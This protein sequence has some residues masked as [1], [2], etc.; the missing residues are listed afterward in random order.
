MFLL[1]WYE[2][3]GFSKA[4]EGIEL[5]ES[6][7]GIRVKEYPEEGLY[8]YNYSQIE[9]PKMRP[10][11][12]ECR[13][14]ILNENL[15]IVCLPFSRF[16][17]I[18]EA[19]E[20]TSKFNI[21]NSIVYEKLDGSLC[22]VY[23]D[24]KT[25]QVA[26]RGTAFAESE[27]YTGEIFQKLILDA[28]ECETLQDFS[29][30]LDLSYIPHTWTLIFEY[31][32]PMNRVVT[33]YKEDCMYLL[34]VRDTVTTADLYFAEDVVADALIRNDLNVKLP[35]TFKFN[36]QE[37]MKEFVNSLDGLQEGVVALDERSGIRIKVKADQYVAI[38]R[39]R[40]D[41]I[42]TPKRI[43]NLIVTNETEEYLAYFPEERMRFE[44]YM[45][46]FAKLQYRIQE[47]WDMSKNIEDQKEFALFVKD[48]MFS[49]VLFQ[50]RQR[51][52]E[53]LHI[54]ATTQVNQKIKLFEK[55]FN[56]KD[57]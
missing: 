5:L 34:G 46:S 36:N 28:F 13:G 54:L 29:N 8:V 19:L 48:Y 3:K 16:F 47:I 55:W 38:H 39:L 43:M 51:E 45:E 23:H 11:V 33:P 35:K 32:S 57:L 17:N 7:F 56:Y 53:P 40:G 49:P 44:P 30:R 1:E 37:E 21:E 42:P 14:L 22:K 26:T 18:G 2:E 52:T 6:E 20:I 25:W 15:E 27:N 4:Q 10:I 41:S 12:M 24:G 50:A 31:T 9:S